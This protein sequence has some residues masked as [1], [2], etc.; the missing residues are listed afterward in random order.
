MTSDF[1]ARFDAAY[2]AWLDKRFYLETKGY[3]DNG[4]GG[5]VPDPQD[6]CDLEA[7]SV[8]IYN[9][10]ARTFDESEPF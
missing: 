2:H 6:P 8:E 7:E 10:P 1:N 3:K 5:L 4:F 9:L